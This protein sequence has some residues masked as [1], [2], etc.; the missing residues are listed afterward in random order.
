[1]QTLKAKKAF[2]LSIFFVN[3]ATFPTIKKI[4]NIFRPI[5]A[6]ISFFSL[7][8]GRCI[9]VE[10]IGIEPPILFRSVIIFSVP[11]VIF[12]WFSLSILISLLIYILTL[13]IGLF[14]LSFPI[15]VVIDEIKKYPWYQFW[16]RKSRKSYA[17]N[18]LILAPKF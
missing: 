7:Y 6:L 11:T 12:F 16:L 18:S 10:A 13:F 5:G 14:T 2:F 17:K 3:I 15:L 4:D 9:V 1:M 8:L